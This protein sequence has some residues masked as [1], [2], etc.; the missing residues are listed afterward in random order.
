MYKTALLSL[1]IQILTFILLVMSFFINIKKDKL[2]LKNVLYLEVIVQIVEIIF[3]IWL[4][5]N[6]SK[7]H[8][9]ITYIRYFDWVISTPVMLFILIIIMEYIHNKNIKLQNIIDNPLILI[10]IFF[11]NFFMLL[12]GYLGETKKISKWISFLLGFLFLLLTYILIFIFYVR[13]NNY[14]LLI[15]WFHI[16]IWSL[17]GYSFLQ[18]YLLK[19]NMYN[20]L[21]IFSKNITAFLIFFYILFTH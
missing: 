21:D 20:I 4:I 9:D 1:I 5:Y 11:S 17:Y 18:P 7:L 14:N 8:Y 3:Y 15:L 12:F 10:I 19:N 13:N 6:F 2:I 16:I